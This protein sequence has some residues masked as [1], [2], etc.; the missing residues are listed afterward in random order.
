MFSRPTDVVAKYSVT[1]QTLRRWAKDGK[2]KSVKTPGGHNRYDLSTF[3]DQQQEK[4]QEQEPIKS[5][6][7]YVYCRVSSSKQ[8]DDLQR[9]KESFQDS[10]PQH[11]II[12]DIGSGLNYKRK[13]FLLLVDKILSDSVSELV[14]AHKDRLC[15]F[16]WELFEWLCSRHRT[17]LVVLHQQEH[18]YEQELGED[19]MA[20]VHVFSCRHHG[21]RRYNKRRYSDTQSETTTHSSSSQ[22]TEKMDD[23]CKTHIQQS[24]ASG[25]EQES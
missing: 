24:T 17:N 22:D 1:K 2:L 10:H 23:L 21:L 14:V 13:G 6:T 3:T 18:S 19:L 20:I 9:Q 15:R 11:T 12:T 8:K 7:A 25:K 4:K 5:R 16:S